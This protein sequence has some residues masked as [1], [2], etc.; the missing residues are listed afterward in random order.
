MLYMPLSDG[1]VEKTMAHD[2]PDAG[3]AVLDFHRRA[4]A[5]LTDAEYA[6][7]TELSDTLW[8]AGTAPPASKALRRVMQKLF[9]DREAV[10]HFRAMGG[11]RAMLRRFSRG[12]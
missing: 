11:T 2:T 9:A 12:G 7:F 8:H 3:H 5:I 6:L 1:A 10:G 4:R